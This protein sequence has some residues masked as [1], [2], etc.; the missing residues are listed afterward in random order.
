M[1]HDLTPNSISLFFISMNLY[2][3]D[4]ISSI[5]NQSHTSFRIRI[6]LT[7]ICIFLRLKLNSTSIPMLLRLCKSMRIPLLPFTNLEFPYPHANQFSSK[8][9]FIRINVINLMPNHRESIRGYEEPSHEDNLETTFARL[10]SSDI[11]HI[12]LIFHELINN[13]SS[14]RVV[15]IIWMQLWIDVYLVYMLRE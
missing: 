13:L 7:S 12:V 8:V 5:H 2:K 14:P 3:W 11:I 1:G 15:L 9:Y 6:K 4:I 10:P